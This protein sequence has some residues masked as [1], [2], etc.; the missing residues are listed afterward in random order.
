VAL[1]PDGEILVGGFYDGASGNVVVRITPGSIT[2]QAGLDPG[3]S[4][5]GIA[6][7]PGTTPTDDG[8]IVVTGDGHILVLDQVLVNGQQSATVV[9]LTSTGTVD[10][11]FGSADGTGAHITADARRTTAKAL[12]L[13]PRG[14]VAVVGFN[15]LSKPFLAKLRKTGRPD[16][17]M[18]PGGV[19]T[20]ASRDGVLAVSA[21]ADGRIIA[22]GSTGIS[23]ES[24]VL[25]LRGDLKPPTCARKKATIVGTA[26]ADTLVGTK[27]ADV[28]AGLRGGDT[29]TGLG[30][31]DII[32]GGPGKDRISGGRGADHLYGG[33]GRD[34]LLGG[35]GHDTIRQ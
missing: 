9:R 4:G 30:R 23:N 7:V 6:D 3:F 29:I 10:N 14:G 26:S 35:P 33:P 32:C 2:T 17:R 19:K 24:V 28:I 11:T 1:Q 31:G 12:T 5:D 34:K 15:D 21:L 13:L 22:A 18:G 8:D 20:L 16:L 27:H 25:R